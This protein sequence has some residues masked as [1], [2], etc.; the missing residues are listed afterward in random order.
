[1]DVALS[2][3]AM[4]PKHADADYTERL[5][6]LPNLGAYYELPKVQ[7]LAVTRG[8]IGLSKDS[9]SFWCPQSLF[10]YQPQFDDVF[11]L[12]VAGAPNVRLVF[13]NYQAVEATTIL[14]ERLSHCFAKVGLAMQEFCIFLP[15]LSQAEFAATAGACD[16]MLD[17]TEWSGFNSRL[18]SLAH[19][20]LL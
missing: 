12:I 20:L 2:S 17:S 6:Q 11:A 10:K 16:A 5:M 9:F 4:E 7:L 19:D 18:E 1:M 13:I 15:R 8:V 3:A 14:V